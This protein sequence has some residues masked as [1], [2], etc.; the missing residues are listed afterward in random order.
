MFDRRRDLFL[1]LV[2]DIAIPCHKVSQTCYIP[3]VHHISYFPLDLQNLPSHSGAQNSLL[4]HRVRS[5]NLASSQLGEHAS[6]VWVRISPPRSHH[7]PYCLII[8][9]SQSSLDQ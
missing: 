2:H 3:A 6:H 9:V 8:L 4:A 5:L 7:V 1:R